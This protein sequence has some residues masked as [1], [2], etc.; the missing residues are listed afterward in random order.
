MPT[1]WSPTKPSHADFPG[2][3][4]LT[5]SDE[6][7]LSSDGNPKL[8]QLSRLRGLFSPG[9]DI[10]IDQYGTISV[11]PVS[12]SVAGTSEYSITNLPTVVTISSGDLV[13]ISQ[14]GSDHTIPYADLIDGLTIDQAQTAAVATGTDT[15]LV[16]QGG[17]VMLRQSLAALWIWLSSQ[18]P[19]Y[20]F[21]TIELTTSVALTAGKH[22][23]RILV[24][25]QP[26]MITLSSADMG[27]G[28]FCNLINVSEGVIT[29]SGEITSSLGSSGIIP[30]QAASL[31]CLSYSGG[32]LSLCLDKFLHTGIRC[33]GTGQR[34][35]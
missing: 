10:S 2:Q 27:N 8:L 15:F 14:A 26:I 21:P 4:T 9:S 11:V 17:N 1:P 28:F 31:T 18:L 30:G 20:A 5:L 13:A 7:V 32:T 23:G 35:R 6:V 12:N 29:L 34:G 3:D 19:S 24:C 33:F 22:N 25:S 16:A